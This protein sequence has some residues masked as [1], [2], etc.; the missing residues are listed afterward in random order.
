MALFQ[1]HYYN[2]LH[3][4]TI[5]YVYCVV[6]YLNNCFTLLNM[7]NIIINDKKK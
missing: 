6:W 2:V 1:L 7:T 5:Y 4:Y 3:K